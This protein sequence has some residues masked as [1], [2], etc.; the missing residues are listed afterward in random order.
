MLRGIFYILI[1]SLSISIMGVFIRE[2]GTGL[3]N[4]TILFS[5][6]LF[7][8]IV[9]LPIALKDKE[10]H[11]KVNKPLILLSRC[12]VGLIAMSLFF[13]AIQHV[14]LANVMLLQNTRPIFVPIIIFM[15]TREKTG[16]NVILAILISFIGIALVI[17]P[18]VGGF[19]PIAI[20]ALLSGFF[21]AAAIILLQ[22]FM[23]QNNNRAKEALFYY[24]LFSTIVTSIIMMF[25]W[26]TPSPHQ[27]LLLLQSELFQFHPNF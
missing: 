24:F 21:S 11:F 25:N 1:S 19:N 26:V 4:S 16:K 3:P 27:I 22:M 9:I 13:Y 8:F 10:F 15:L 20:F 17:N 14:H 23:K 5:R 7:S 12:S 18:T 6:F 2:I